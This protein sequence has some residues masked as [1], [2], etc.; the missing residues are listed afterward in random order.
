MPA[1]TSDSGSD[2]SAVV[3][4]LESLIYVV[5][6][7]WIVDEGFDFFC[8]FEVLNINIK[9]AVVPMHVYF[10]CPKYEMDI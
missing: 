6:Y 8:T 3:L 4:H 10:F 5:P 1:C 9:L 2:K 7:L